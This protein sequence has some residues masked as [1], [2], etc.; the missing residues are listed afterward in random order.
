MQLLEAITGGFGRPFWPRAMP[1]L[2]AATL[3]SDA[4]WRNV[5]RLVIIS[6]WSFW[7]GVFLTRA[8]SVPKAARSPPRRAPC[9]QVGLPV[10]YPAPPPAA[11]LPR[12]DGAPF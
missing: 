8:V 9:R 5:R 7:V 3:K 12:N 2:A 10:P 1:R 6:V 11:L 4:R